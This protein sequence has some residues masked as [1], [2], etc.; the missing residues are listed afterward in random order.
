MDGK[1]K[2][3][4]SSTVWKHPSPGGWFFISLPKQISEEIRNHFKWQEEG[5]GRLKVEAQIGNYKWDT[6]IWFDTK[7]ETYLLPIKAEI[8]SILKLEIKKNSE[9]RIWV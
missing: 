2:Y 9:I 5:W 7:L 1:I 4:F 6:A 8:R 3:E